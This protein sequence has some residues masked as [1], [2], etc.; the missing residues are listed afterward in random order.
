MLSLPSA[1]MYTIWQIG[2]HLL[3]YLAK[4]DFIPPGCRLSAPDE[5]YLLRSVLAAHQGGGAHAAPP[6]LGRRAA[7][8]EAAFATRAAGAALPGALTSQLTH[9][10][11]GGPVVLDDGLEYSQVLTAAPAWQRRITAINYTRVDEGLGAIA[12][13]LLLGAVSSGGLLGAAASALQIKDS[14]KLESESRGFWLIYELLT[15]GL[16]LRVLP[17][18]SGNLLH[19]SAA[20]T[21]RRSSHVCSAVRCVLMHVR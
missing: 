19:R 10:A 17:D 5:L 20:R 9:V 8:L 3:L 15:S 13:R 18:D 11:G 16:Q 12:L 14:L 6:L 1:D 7:F 4:L 21:H 2:E